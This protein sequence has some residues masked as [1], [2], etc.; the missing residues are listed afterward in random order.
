MSGILDIHTQFALENGYAEIMSD[1][2][3]FRA[4]FVGVADAVLMEW[5]NELQARK[6]LFRDAAG[7]GPPEAKTPWVVVGL[8]DEHGEER[9]IGNSGGSDDDGNEFK[10]F[11][12]S[13]DVRV[14]ILAHNGEI[15]RALH[16]VLRAAALLATDAFLA[17]GYE[18]WSY[19][20]CDPLTPEEELMTVELGMFMRVQR[21]TGK[22]IVRAV[23]KPT[24]PTG[25]S[26]FVQLDGV[27]DT[28]GQVPVGVTVPGPGSGET[29]GE[30]G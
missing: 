22:S 12:V 23:K 24:A 3:A 16:V 21:Y 1:A 11:V 15:C 17:G 26:W 19:V 6:P 7:K 25:L 27:Q 5:Y 14:T 18:D 30:R 8:A 10:E 29:G 13:Q 9:F 20:G 2:A 4:L 28:V